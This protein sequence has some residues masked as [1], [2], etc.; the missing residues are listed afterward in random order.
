MS[1]LSRVF[2]SEKVPRQD[3]AELSCLNQRLNGYLVPETFQLTDQPFLDDLTVM[4][5]KERLSAFL[6]GGTVL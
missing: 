6:V 5:L 2:S 4:F 3:Q 1:W